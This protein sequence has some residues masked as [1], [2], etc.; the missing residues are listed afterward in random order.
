MPRID[1]RIRVPEVRLIDENGEQAGVV[2][3]RDALER[4]HSL[5][6][7][8]VEIS[9][10]ARPP[11]CRITNYGKYRYEQSKKAHQNKKNAMVTKLKEVQF[12][13]NVDV[14]DYQV[15]VRRMKGFLREGSRVKVSLSFRGRENAHKDLGYALIERILSDVR[16]VGI[17]EQAPK[18]LGRN[19][20]MVVMP[21]T[22]GRGGGD[23]LAKSLE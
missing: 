12:R 17:S 16:E 1:N 20:V 5:G 9:A 15:K 10:N 8:L 21:N 2:Y 23:R 13:P 4:A 14:A 22:K 11:V 18:Q 19:V 6:L 3:T 7:N